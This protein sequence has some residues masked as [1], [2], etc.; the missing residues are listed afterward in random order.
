MAQ[1]Q[2]SLMV[3]FESGGLATAT[4]KDKANKDLDGLT[5]FVNLV[6][7]VGQTS[8]QARVELQNV[9]KDLS[10]Q[11]NLKCKAIEI[12]LELEDPSIVTTSKALN[13]A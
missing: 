3:R 1:P 8:G 5:N 13:L 6:V 10:T 2:G 4:L 11:V 7:E 9:G 12:T